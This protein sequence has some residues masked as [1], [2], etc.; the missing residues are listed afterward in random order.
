MLHK[1]P[2]SKFSCSAFSLLN[3]A[4]LCG[5]CPLVVGGDAAASS[6]V[7]HSVNWDVLKPNIYDQHATEMEPFL[8]FCFYS[9]QISDLLPKRFPAKV[10]VE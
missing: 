7:A 4:F 1:H 9:A 6:T 10:Q 3:N 5:C 8:V 2:K